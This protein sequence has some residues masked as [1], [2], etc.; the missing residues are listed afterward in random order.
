M[1][2]AV[3]SLVPAQSVLTVPVSGSGLATLVPGSS[4]PEH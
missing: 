1:S 3:R 2:A 4:C